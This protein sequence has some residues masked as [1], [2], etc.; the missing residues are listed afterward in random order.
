MIP[1][2]ELQAEA[3]TTFR[4]ERLAREMLEASL[5]QV[6]AQPVIVPDDLD[7]RVR[8]FLA[9]NPKATWDQAVRAIMLG[10]DEA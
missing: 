4:R 9:A 7:E 10:E 3:Y 8:A 1:S 5:A 6:N 2:P